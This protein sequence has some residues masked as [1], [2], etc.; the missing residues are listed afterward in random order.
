MTMKI[1]SLLNIVKMLFIE[2]EIKSTKNIL[3]SEEL[4]ISRNVLPQG[5]LE[6]EIDKSTKKFIK[7]LRCWL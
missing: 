7:K 1:I 3:P 4:N 5:H 2:N 6:S